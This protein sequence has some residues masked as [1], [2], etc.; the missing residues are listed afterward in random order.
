MIRLAAV[1]AST[2][3]CAGFAA[4]APSVAGTPSVATTPSGPTWAPT[5]T[6]PSGAATTPNAAGTPSAT[7]Q[8]TAA[9]AARTGKTPSSGRT[10][11]AGATHRQCFAYTPSG[12]VKL[13]AAHGH[14]LQSS[15]CA[16]ISWVFQWRFLEPTPG[17]YDWSM[18]DAALAASGAKPVVLRVV[19]GVT[20]PTWLPRTDGIIAPD[21]KGGNSWMP[22]PWNANFLATWKTFINAFGAR[23]NG[24][25]H[26]AMIEGGGDGP[27]GEAHLTGTYA[28]WQAVGYSV[29]TYVGA[30]STEIADFKSAFPSHKISFAGASTTFA[31]PGQPNV[32]QAFLSACETARI[33]VQNN[34]LT[35]TQ[36]GHINQ[37]V[38][39]FGFQTAS[40]QGSGLGAALRL[41]TSLGAAFVEVYYVDATNPALYGAIT[42]FQAS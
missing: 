36:Y 39:E 16:G 37:N 10:P 41:A 31:A 4:T 42:T 35:G 30:I 7:A 1:L 34:G 38:I 21:P 23:Y 19:G 17:G 8:L 24:N 28:L 40:A 5:A 12:S 25:T 9:K 22:I 29:Q 15:P 26:I 32:G 18:V 6:T 27:Q 20:S 33:V 3:L 13:I 11:S 2:T 14:V